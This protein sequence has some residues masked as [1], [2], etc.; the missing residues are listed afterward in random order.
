MPAKAGETQ[1]TIPLLVTENHETLPGIIPFFSTRHGGVSQ[2]NCTSLNLGQQVQDDPQAVAINRQRIVEALGE[3]I[4]WSSFLHQVH[5][6]T[7]VTADAHPWPRPPE[8]DAQITRQSGVLLAILTADCAPL[9]FA[10][11]QERIIGAAHAGW[12]GA[13][14]GVVESC[15]NEM[16]AAG[17]YVNQ[18]HAFLGPCIHAASYEVD[19]PFYNTF[20]AQAEKMRTDYKKFFSKQNNIGKL[21]FDLPGYLRERLETYGLSKERIHDAKQCTY[22]RNSDFFSHRYATQRNT[23]PCGRQMGG[24]LL[25]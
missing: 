4:H 24:I 23:A 15:L 11:P 17:A 10:D 19:P 6:T 9:L 14:Y 13:L 25:V 22:S 20:A 5:G 7:T 3:K 12:R 16:V 8:A 21:R 1:E 18:I 2:G